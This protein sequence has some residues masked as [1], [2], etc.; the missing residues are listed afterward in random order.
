MTD[1]ERSDDQEDNQE[2]G[3]EDGQEDDQ[4]ADDQFVNT[5]AIVRPGAFIVH[6]QRSTPAHLWKNS[7]GCL[8]LHLHLSPLRCRSLTFH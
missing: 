4:L 6:A 1:V 3:R 2:D 5:T 7:K 8:P